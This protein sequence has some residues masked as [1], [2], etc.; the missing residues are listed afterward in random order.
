MMN[1]T[2]N[3]F[4]LPEEKEQFIEESFPM[5]DPNQVEK[6]LTD[7]FIKMQENMP[8]HDVAAH[9]FKMYYPI[10]VQLLSGLSNKDAR[11]VAQHVVQWPLEDDSPHFNDE[12]AKQAFAVGIRLNDCKM[13]M[14]TYVEMERTQEFL[15]QKEEQE[16]NKEGESNNGK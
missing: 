12:K 11:R 16:K 3:S 15:K 4:A 9:F 1:D 5:V 13:I 6:E 2:E 10:Y 7:E 8:A 14:R